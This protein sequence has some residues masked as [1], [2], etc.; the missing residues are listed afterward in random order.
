M[1]TPRWLDLRALVLLH[2]ETLAEHGGLPGLRDRAALESA[3][4]RPRNIFAY[5]STTDVPRLAAAYAFGIIQDHPFVDGNKRVGFVAA[6][7]FLQL[8]GYHLEADEAEAIGKVLSLAAGA[9]TE[10][11][12]VEWLRTHSFR[13]NQK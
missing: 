12:F 10:N 5:K 6:A 11:E 7:L 13:Q 3:L 1:K 4:A 8:N 2:A 9:L